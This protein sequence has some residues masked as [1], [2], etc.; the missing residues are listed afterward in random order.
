MAFDDREDVSTE[1]RR[2]WWGNPLVWLG[3]AAIF[4]LLGIFVTSRLFGGTIIFLP[5]FWIRWPRARKRE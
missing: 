3:V 5:F 2:P 4:L 1:R